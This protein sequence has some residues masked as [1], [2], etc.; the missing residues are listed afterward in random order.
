M[1]QEQERAKLLE[2]ILCLIKDPYRT[3]DDI[4][5]YSAIQ[6]AFEFIAGVHKRTGLKLT[7][8][9]ANELYR[10]GLIDDAPAAR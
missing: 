4:A 2:E 7:A 5:H 6:S 1:T 10:R 8:S 9:L 3:W